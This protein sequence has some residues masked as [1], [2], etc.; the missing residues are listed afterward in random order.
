MKPPMANASFTITSNKGPI[1]GFKYRYMVAQ[2]GDFLASSVDTANPIL[3]SPTFS[4]SG[5]SYT[6]PLDLPLISDD[7]PEATGSVT[8]YFIS[9]N[10]SF[11]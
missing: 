1:S 7:D 8:S 4:G 2:V 3:G 9:Q 5:N 10:S 11:K 6:A